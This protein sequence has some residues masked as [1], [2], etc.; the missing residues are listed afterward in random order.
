[1]SDAPVTVAPVACSGETYSAVPITMPV[2]VR[3]ASSEA[4]ALAMPKSVIFVVP[5]AVISRL[6]GLMSRCTMPAW[7]ATSRARAACATMSI[8]TSAGSRP[9]RSRIVDS[10]SPFTSSMTRYGPPSGLVSP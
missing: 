2:A 10:G 4:R 1:M 8:V 5:S 9:S 3:F 7:C 6:P